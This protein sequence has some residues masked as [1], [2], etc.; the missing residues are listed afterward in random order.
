[1]ASC[2]M[3][4]S[5]VAVCIS[6]L[7][8]NAVR[9]CNTLSDVLDSDANSI[10]EKT[11]S[12]STK[13]VI[14]SCLLTGRD[15]FES[16]FPRTLRTE[17]NENFFS[18]MI[19]PVSLSGYPLLEPTFG[20]FRNFTRK[21]YAEEKTRDIRW[22]MLTMLS[23]IDNIYCE[24][25]DKN[26]VI[27]SKQLIASPLVKFCTSKDDISDECKN[28]N[29]LDPSDILQNCRPPGGSFDPSTSSSQIF[30]AMIT[31]NKSVH[32]YDKWTNEWQAS[33]LGNYSKLINDTMFMV[34][35]NGNALTDMNAAQN[36][37]GMYMNLKRIE[38]RLCK[39]MISHF[40]QYSHSFI[41]LMIF[42]VVFAIVYILQY[43]LSLDYSGKATK[44]ETP[45]TPNE[46]DKKEGR[47]RTFVIDDVETEQRP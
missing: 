38:M 44:I 1:M 15:N 9:K 42:V 39:D 36:C 19:K 17:V 26:G 18:K 13:F 46:E 21:P 11:P 29:R 27:T 45:P 41:G 23:G 14:K 16:V 47:S 40:K 35:A 5:I 43:V 20:E 24:W 25:K 28:V 22:D 7:A 8:I 6:Y 31:Y 4:V 3:L 12:N 33:L 37:T 10:L 34:D 32:D 2:A 30:S